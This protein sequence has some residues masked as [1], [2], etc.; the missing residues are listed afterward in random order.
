VRQQVVS[1]DDSNGNPQ[2]LV[3]AYAGQVQKKRNKESAQQKC[4]NPPLGLMAV[5][6]HDGHLSMVTIL[7]KTGKEIIWL[8]LRNCVLFV[9]IIPRTRCRPRMEANTCMP[10]GLLFI[11]SISIRGGFRR[12]G[13]PY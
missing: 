5:G 12:L 9:T 1:G 6:F 8:L 11:Y 4:V 10:A 2:S 3:H 13:I 7:L